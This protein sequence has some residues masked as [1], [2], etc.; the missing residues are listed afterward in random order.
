[1]EWNGIPLDAAGCNEG[2]LGCERRERKTKAKLL[3]G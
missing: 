2:R 3:A 1:M